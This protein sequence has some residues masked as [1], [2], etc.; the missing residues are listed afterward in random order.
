MFSTFYKIVHK[1]KKRC[2]FGAYFHLLL[3]VLASLDPHAGRVFED[4]SLN[5]IFVLLENLYYYYIKGFVQEPQ[6]REKFYL[7]KIFLINFFFKFNL[8]QSKREKKE[9]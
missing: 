5:G 9:R 2:I 7:L 4:T 1:S 3:S 8:S 6:K